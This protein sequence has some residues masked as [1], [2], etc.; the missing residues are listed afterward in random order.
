LKQE[1]SPQ[2]F[3]AEVR[4]V[5]RAGQSSA[6]WITVDDTGTRRYGAS[7]PRG[8]LDAPEAGRRN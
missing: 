4:Q 3:L 2:A 7:P 8:A 6:A 5:L 1:S